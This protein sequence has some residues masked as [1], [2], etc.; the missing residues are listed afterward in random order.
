[1]PRSHFDVCTNGVTISDD[2]RRPYA[3]RLAARAC[4]GR[5]SSH[6][7]RSSTMQQ[8]DPWPYDSE[9]EWR[10][11]RTHLD[12]LEAVPHIDTL[13]RAADAEIARIV[14]CREGHWGA[15]HRPARAV[16]VAY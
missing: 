2:E 7:R 1:M 16:D 6:A 10:L 13:K 15:P 8:P 5:V 11:W 9:A 4:C 3:S 14:R 12:H